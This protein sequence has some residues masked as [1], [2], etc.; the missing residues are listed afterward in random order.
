MHRLRT[1]LA[2]AALAAAPVAAQSVPP[3]PGDGVADLARV[4]APAQADSLRALI[5]GLRAAPGVE[6]RVLTVRG[7]TAH[8]PAAASPEAFA[9]AVYNAWLV[10]YGQRQDGVLVLLSVDDRFTRIELGD[11]VPLAQDARMQRIVDDAMVPRFRDGDHGGGLVAGVTEVARSFRAPP[12]AEAG[13]ETGAIPAVPWPLVSA[14]EPAPRRDDG[15]AAGL[16]AAL[17]LVG[18]V[19]GALAYSASLR[20]RPRPCPECRTMMVL[21]GEEGDDVHLDSGRRLEEAMGSVDYD[22]WRCPGCRSTSVRAYPKFLSGKET[23]G[24]CRYRTVVRETRTLERA[25][26]DHGGRQQVTRDCRHCG[27]HDDDVIHT[28]RLRR[29]DGG[30]WSGGPGGSGGSISRLGGGSPGGRSSGGGFSSGRGA[31]GRW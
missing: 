21:L 31:S 15:F 30:S 16:F 27:W 17:V 9:T 13:S 3:E 2:A 23:C 14:P 28:P 24:A 20:R 6:V 8:D 29:H 1:A 10:G 25:T 11:G 19:V 7:I 26:Y 4:L 18:G 5:A 12:G 22:V